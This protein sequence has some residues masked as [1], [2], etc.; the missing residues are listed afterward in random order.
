MRD[1]PWFVLT[2]HTLMVGDVRR[3]ELASTL[4]KGA[5]DLYDSLYNKLMKLDDHVEVYPGAYSESV[6]GRYLSG[7][8]S[9]T[10]GFERRLNKALQ[11]QS[12]EEFV[13]FMTKDLPPQPENYEKIRKLNEGKSK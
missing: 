1:E 6:C 8:P 3:T 9:S 10:I 7:K 13:E 11:K 12:K 4:G 5:I 2:G